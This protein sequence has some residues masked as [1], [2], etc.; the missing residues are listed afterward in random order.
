[1]IG[2]SQKWIRWI[3]LC[4]EI[5]DYSIIVN[6]H[7][8]GHVVLGRGLRQGDLLSLYLFIIFAEGLTAL[9]RQAE[10]RGNLHIRYQNM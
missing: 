2:F 4:V 5:V 7:M 1:M 3:M 10:N 9:I 8:V 6:F